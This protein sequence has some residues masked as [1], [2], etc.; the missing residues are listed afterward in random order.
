[1][2]AML[3]AWGGLLALAGNL[4]GAEYVRRMAGGAL[5]GTDAIDPF[6]LCHRFFGGIL[7]D[8]DA[9][10]GLR[11][12][13]ERPPQG[14]AFVIQRLTKGVMVTV[15]GVRAGGWPAFLPALLSLGP[16]TLIAGSILGLGPKKPGSDG[17]IDT[18]GCFWAAA[19]F[20]VLTV[21]VGGAI[22]FALKWALHGVFWTL[23][24][25]ATLIVYASPLILAIGKVWELIETGG[26][27]RELATLVVTR[28]SPEASPPP[29]EPD[30]AA[31][32]PS[33]GD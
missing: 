11:P 19:L 25:T 4:A 18:L 9:P 5:K 29:A 23:G 22:A 17:A 31:A 20:L 33:P 32:P 30:G 15:D 2:L 14:P 10:V 13:A 21:L 1:M 8:Y 7:G 28:D 12:W 27:V 26:K 6:F 24:S 16:G 3:L